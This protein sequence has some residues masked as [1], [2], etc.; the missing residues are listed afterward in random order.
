MTASL[1]SIHVLIITP[2]ENQNILSKAKLPC[3]PLSP[4]SEESYRGFNYSPQELRA[5]A[6][7]HLNVAVSPGVSKARNK[8]VLYP[9]SSTYLCLFL[10]KFI[11]PSQGPVQYSLTLR[12]VPLRSRENSLKINQKCCFISERLSGR[13]VGGR[14][15]LGH[16]WGASNMS[17]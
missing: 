16:S 8:S 2:I 12:N 3:S 13:C 11:Y 14:V 10:V 7:T 6:E 4:G 17:S 15:L 5:E 1:N 9:F